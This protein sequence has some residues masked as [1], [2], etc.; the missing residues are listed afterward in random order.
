MILK[1]DSPNQDSDKEEVTKKLKHFPEVP[2]F[3]FMQGRIQAVLSTYSQE[4]KST[5]KN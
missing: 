2:I 4:M 5:I 1:E 3:D